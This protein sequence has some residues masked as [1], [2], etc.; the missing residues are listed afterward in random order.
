MR[1]GVGIQETSPRC[2]LLACEKLTNP[3]GKGSSYVEEVGEASAD[4]GAASGKVVALYRGITPLAKCLSHHLSLAAENRGE[5]VPCER[6]VGKKSLRR[7]ERDGVN[8]SS[9]GPRRGNREYS[10]TWKTHTENG[11]PGQGRSAERLGVSPMSSPP[12]TTSP[13]P[14]K[15]RVR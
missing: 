7:R 11:G 12:K 15:K 2:L 1:R 13:Y 14:L 3:Q 4:R 6:K 5:S 10:E 9:D 8:L